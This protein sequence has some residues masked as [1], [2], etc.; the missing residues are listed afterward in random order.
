[1]EK[2]Q[3]QF[4]TSYT[5]QTTDVDSPSVNFG[6]RSDLQTTLFQS[7]GDII[8]DAKRQIGTTE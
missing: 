6:Q 1:M 4:T 7:L 5:Q 3:R 2:V 8:A